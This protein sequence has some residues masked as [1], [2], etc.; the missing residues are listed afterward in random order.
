M[1]ALI[2]LVIIVTTIAHRKYNKAFSLQETT[3]SELK[4]REMMEERML[5]EE[6]CIS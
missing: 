2:I 3:M 1:A 5:K 6:V 4:L